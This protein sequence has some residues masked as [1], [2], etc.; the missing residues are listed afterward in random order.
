MKLE[1]LQETRPYWLPRA[2]LKRNELILMKLLLQLQDLKQSESF[3]PMLFIQ[4]FKVYHMDVKSAF[5]NGELDEEVYIQQPPGFKDLDFPEFIYRLFRALYGLKQA[6]RAWYD[7][8][9]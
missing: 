5:L 2:T 1:L 6:P 8:L 4:N 3:Y 7:T 9:S